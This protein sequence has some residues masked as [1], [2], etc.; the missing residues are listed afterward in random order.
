MSTAAAVPCLICGAAHAPFHVF[1]KRV[2]LNTPMN[3]WRG[4]FDAPAYYAPI[5]RGI[6]VALAYLVVAII[7]GLVAFRRRD[8]TGG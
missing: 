4:M 6:V 2:L 8:V 7:A 3:A 1:P 5:E